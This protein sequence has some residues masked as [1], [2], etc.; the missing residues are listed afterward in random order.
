[1]KIFKF[2]FKFFC[3]FTILFS[4]TLNSFA[5]NLN[6]ENNLHNNTNF[7]K[8]NNFDV[9][10]NN[11][12]LLWSNLENS[13]WIPKDISSAIDSDFNVIGSFEN[14]LLI[15][16][17]NAVFSYSETFGLKS[18]FE[19]K[20]AFSIIKSISSD[21]NFHYFLTFN[22][23]FV[24]KNNVLNKI[25]LPKNFNA[26]NFYIFDN[27]FYILGE[28]NSTSTLLRSS[29]LINFENLDISKF[30]SVSSLN[31]YD[32]N[33][34][35]LQNSG[36]IFK[37]KNFKNFIKICNPYIGDRSHKYTFNDL[38]IINNSIYAYG[39][40]VHWQ[41]EFDIEGNLCKVDNL[42][43]SLIFNEGDCSFDDLKFFNNKFNLLSNS[44]YNKVFSSY[45][46]TNWS[47]SFSA[48]E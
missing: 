2:F 20:D 9:F 21:Y 24:Y 39:N 30:N 34:F 15:N 45:D 29:D 17:Q 42:N 3:F 12:K 31:Y 5:N 37:T 4:F 32:N 41:N 43:L 25:N 23:I 40:G 14:L 10:F 48:N 46:L 27:K 13:V 19:T 33:F 11:Q 18:L 28:S 44:N 6:E 16:S 36:Q 35:I 26:K 22:S 1:M 7:F 47:L 8:Y 38:I